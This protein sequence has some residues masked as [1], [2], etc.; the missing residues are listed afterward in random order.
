MLYT[1]IPAFFGILVHGCCRSVDAHP[2]ADPN[3]RHQ[4]L[5]NHKVSSLFGLLSTMLYFLL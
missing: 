3:R 5:V 2:E 4:Y 1:M